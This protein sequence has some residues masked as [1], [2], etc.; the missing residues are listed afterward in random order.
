VI[1]EEG[2]SRPCFYCREPIDPLDRSV[3]RR[4][5]GW[6]RKGFAESRRGGSDIVLREPRDE[7]ACPGCVVRLQA[8]LPVAQESLL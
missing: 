1:D 5:V 2:L 7:Y 8:G 4:V 6:E 3:W